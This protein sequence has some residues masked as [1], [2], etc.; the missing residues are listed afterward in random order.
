MGTKFILH[1]LAVS[2]L[3]LLSIS[4]G[5]VEEEEGPEKVVIPEAVDLGL[6]VKWASFD[7]GAAK[8]G[9]VGYYVAWGETAPKDT[10]YKW[11]EYAWCTGSDRSLTKYNYKADYGSVLDYRIALKQDDDIAHVL[12]GGEWRTPTPDEMKELIDC[13]FLTQS[14]ENVDG[15]DCLRL[16]SAKTGNS[17]LFPAAGLCDG[18]IVPRGRNYAGYYWSSTIDYSPY[19]F[20][21]ASINPSV[22]NFMMVSPEVKTAGFSSMYMSTWPRAH[23]LNVRAV[24]G[25][26]KQ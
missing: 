11:S 7:V 12:F 14:V 9:Q 26:E 5:K 13:P 6:S 1:V 24:Y 8:P 20:Q 19:L 16:T 18:T 17:I 10:Y 4:C 25:A 2:I 22:A 23:G 21:A 15:V 3:P